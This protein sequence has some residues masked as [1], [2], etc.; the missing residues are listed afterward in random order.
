MTSLIT[1]RDSKASLLASLQDNLDQLFHD[2]SK[3]GAEDFTKHQQYYEGLLKNSLDC[4]DYLGD[5]P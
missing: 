1:R 2:F 3:S 4:L 5:K